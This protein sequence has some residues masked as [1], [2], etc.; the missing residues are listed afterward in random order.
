M[1]FL[2]QADGPGFWH[3]TLGRNR[4]MLERFKGLFSTSSKGH[5]PQP[6]TEHIAAGSVRIEGRAHKLLRWSRQ[7][8]VASPAEAHYTEGDEIAFDATVTAGA[9]T[10]EFNGLAAIT[11]VDAGANELHCQ[12]IDIDRSVLPAIDRHFKALEG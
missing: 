7:T 9:E 11:K 4:A 3:D 5:R 10:L 6:V 2:T 12:F 8:F 1:R